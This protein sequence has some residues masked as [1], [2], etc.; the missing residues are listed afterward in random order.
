MLPD[1]SWRT[2]VQTVK[3]AAIVVLLMTGLYGTYV[4]LTTPPEPLPEE[5]QAML[6]FDPELDFAIDSGLPDSL[7]AF[8]LGEDLASPSDLPI[9]SVTQ[10]DPSEDGELATE[11]PIEMGLPREIAGSPNLESE[12]NQFAP[13][14]AIDAE[15]N[16]LLNAST[17]SPK[18]N[19]GIS[20]NIPPA[21]SQRT[22]PNTLATEVLTPNLGLTNAIETADRQFFDDKRRDALA[23]LS[24]FYNAPNMTS[25]QRGQLLSRLDPLAREVIYSKRHLLEQPYRVGQEETLMDVASIHQV[26]WQLLANINQIADPVTVLPGTELKVVRGPFRAEV[27]LEMKEMTLFLGD[28]YAGRFPVEVG[29]DPTPSVG[30]YTIQEKKSNKTYYD[31]E[32]SAVAPGSPEN[33]YGDVWMDLGGMVSIHGS[34]DFGAPTDQGCIS[35]AADYARDLYGIL[36]PGSSVT[37]RR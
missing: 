13:N 28:L 32:G 20:G 26:P 11:E 24:I 37:I 5:V 6:D 29:T 8:D 2:S 15:A 17:H 14:F 3:T 16:Q 10:L 12:Q 9:N 35:L 22:Q 7:D 31:R 23:T 4:S 36:S 21:A 25:E 33:P 19:S 18:T 1:E 27:N 30:T 34:P